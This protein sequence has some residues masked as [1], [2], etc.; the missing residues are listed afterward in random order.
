M[1][2]QGSCGFGWNARA[3]ERSARVS[4]AGRFGRC[5]RRGAAST[6]ISDGLRRVTLFAPVLRVWRLYYGVSMAR[7][8]NASLPGAIRTTCSRGWATAVTNP[9]GAAAVPK[10]R[11]YVLSILTLVY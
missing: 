8:S 1:F 3:T 6:W 5:L 9:A 4:P 11:W 7:A 10:D 2:L